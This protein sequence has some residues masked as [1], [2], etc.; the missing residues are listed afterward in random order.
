MSLSES[1]TN[2]NPV[3]I[4]EDEAALYDRQIRLWGLDAQQKMR[5]A[6]ILIIRLNGTATETVKNIVL[7]G[8]GRILILD[9]KNVS[10]EDLG[11]GFFFRDEDVGK[12]RA[13]AAKPRIQSLNPL[14]QVDAITSSSPADLEGLKGILSSESVDL[15][16][17][18]DFPR[19]YLIQVNDICRQSGKSFYAGGTYGLLGYIFCDLLIHH[20]ISPDRNS[21]SKEGPPKNIKVSA[22]Y[23]PLSEALHYKWAELSKRQTKEL[24]PAAIFTILAVWEFESRKGIL[25]TNPEDLTE[26]EALTQALIATTGVNPQVLSKP[27]SDLLRTVPTS[28]SHEFS[29]ICAIIGGILAQDI[30]KA[31]AARE[32]PI[33]NMFAFDGNTGRGTVCRMNMGPV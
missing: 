6:T 10:Q 14:V 25:P 7:A 33:A 11:A 15:V 29:P 17:A 27:P 12:H 18:T 9:E 24:N 5:N 16:C 8:V 13:E 19:D 22:A 1:S 28:V 3:Q 23:P 2:P 31:L 30:L 20:Y 4:T 21:G 26:L 32:P